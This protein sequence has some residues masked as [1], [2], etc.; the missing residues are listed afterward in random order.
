MWHLL[1]RLFDRLVTNSILSPLHRRFVR[2]L[3]RSVRSTWRK[4][5]APVASVVGGNVG[6][7]VGQALAEAVRDL[8]EVAWPAVT[9]WV[10]HVVWYLS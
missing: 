4:I 8:C 7:P 6:G 9:L 10:L 5:A 3:N 1:H 2:P